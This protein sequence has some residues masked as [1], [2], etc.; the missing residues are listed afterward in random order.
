MQNPASPTLPEVAQFI[1]RLAA[2]HNAEALRFMDEF[3]AFKARFQHEQ[4]SAELANRQRA[5]GFNIFDFFADRRR[6][7][8]HSDFLAF[9][10][11]PR[12]SHAQGHLFI[13]SFF[14]MARRADPTLLLPSGPLD[15]GFWLVEREVFIQDGFLDIVLRNPS[16][17]ALYV[18]ENKIDADEQTGQL[19]RYGAY[20]ERQGHP[21][22]GLL[23]LTLDGHESWTSKGVRYSQLSYRHDIHTWIETI[24][25]RVEAP[26][27][28]E[29]VRQYQ[30]LI[31]KL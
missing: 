20:L 4:Q 7:K 18:I 12:A 22:Q 10:L 16:L 9:L 25:P 8:F 31:H 30:A 2:L 5:P 28:R 15:H 1:Q 27:V 23:F 19:T 3:T 14:E 24:L 17:G 26:T 13:E 21:F 6:E 11:N 29:T